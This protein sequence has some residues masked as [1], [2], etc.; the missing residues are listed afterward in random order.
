MILFYSLPI[1]HRGLLKAEKLEVAG[2]WEVPFFQPLWD[3]GRVVGLEDFN[4][5][6]FDCLGFLMSSTGVALLKQI[7]SMK[8]FNTCEAEN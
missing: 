6:G 4:S 8:V 5:I 3:A 7:Q 1:K 2:S